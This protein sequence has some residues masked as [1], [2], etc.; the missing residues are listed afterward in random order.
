MLTVIVTGIEV[1]LGAM[2]VALAARGVAARRIPVRDPARVV[3]SRQAGSR[4]VAR[5]SGC[6]GF[7]EFS[8]RR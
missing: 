3:R 7:T 2:L 1:A 6:N 8:E 4:G 5:S